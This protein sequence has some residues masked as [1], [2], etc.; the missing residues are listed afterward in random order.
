[1]IAYDLFKLKW[2]HETLAKGFN[3]GF[4]IKIKIVRE[5]GENRN[6]CIECDFCMHKT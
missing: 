4:G 1:M 5:I 6:K 3:C 2:K